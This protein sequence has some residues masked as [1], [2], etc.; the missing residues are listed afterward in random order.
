MKATPKKKIILRCLCHWEILLEQLLE[1]SLRDSG[2]RISISVPSGTKIQ[3]IKVTS[4]Y[5]TNILNGDPAF[6][7]S[8]W[9]TS[10]QEKKRPLMIN[11]NSLTARFNHLLHVFIQGCKGY[12]SLNLFIIHVPCYQLVKC[13]MSHSNWIPVC[14]CVFVLAKYWVQKYSFYSQNEDIYGKLRYFSR[15]SQ[16]KGLAVH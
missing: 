15:S 8:G 13:S 1:D 14:V 9:K 10:F 5:T 4:R 11:S 2:W 6:R 3:L 7:R 12:C 16:F